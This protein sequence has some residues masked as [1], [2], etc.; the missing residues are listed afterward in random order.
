MASKLN[1]SM[2]NKRAVGP[3]PEPL[4]ARRDGGS[5][6]WAWRSPSTGE[7]Q[8]TDPSPL[9]RNA[10]GFILNCDPPMPIPTPLFSPGRGKAA[11]SKRV[12]KNG[13]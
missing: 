8:R 13:G 4:R 2:P 12:L 1:T 10:P 7:R 5:H 3:P 9:G 6:E 11:G